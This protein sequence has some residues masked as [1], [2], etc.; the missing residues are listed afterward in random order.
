MGK[1]KFLFD[2]P[3][4]SE[5]ERKDALAKWWDNQGA[6][7]YYNDYSQGELFDEEDYESVS[8]K[9]GAASDWWRGYFGKNSRSRFYG[10]YGGYIDDGGEEHE[11]PE[12]LRLKDEL[13]Q[14]AR[15]VNAVR[16]TS[17]A[18]KRERNLKVAWAGQGFSRADH[19]QNNMRSTSTIYISPD[20][21]TE[22][23]TIKAK[24][25]EGQKRDA[26]VGEALS[27]TA[28]KRI[29]QPSHVKQIMAN[30]QP[31]EYIAQLSL[32]EIDE[33]ERAVQLMI[34][35]ELWKSLE[36]YTAQQDL[37]KDYRGC[38]A[39]FAAYLAFY[40]D[41]GYKS[42]L[43]A[44]MQDEPEKIN[45]FRAAAVL[46]W[47]IN[48]FGH[49]S[50][51][52]NPP[53]GDVEEIMI[54][55]FEV[56]MEGLNL[57]STSQRW[58]KAVEAAQI[59]RDLDPEGKDQDQ[60][61]LDQSG[62]DA[63]DFMD[64]ANGANGNTENMF[65]AQVQNASQMQ[66]Q[67]DCDDLED[68]EQASSGLTEIS[69]T[70][71]LHEVTDASLAHG[72]M[73][74]RWNRSVLEADRIADLMRQI[75]EETAMVLAS[76][77]KV[78]EPYAHLPVLPEY[79]M[80]SG[81]LS[82]SSL[83]KVTTNL[84]DNDRVFFRK[85]TQGVTNKV[86]IGLLLDYSGST[87]GGVLDC[88]KRIAVILNDLFSMFHQVDLHLFGHE[89]GNYNNIYHFESLKGTLAYDSGGGTNEGTALACA[90]KALNQVTPRGRRKI[91]FAIGDG[92]TGPDEIKASVK[93][94][95]QSG[96]EVYDILVTQ[97]DDAKHQAVDC[98]GEGRVVTLDPWTEIQESN[99]S[100]SYGDNSVLIDV[101]MGQ[102]TRIMRPWLVQMFA[103]LNN[104]GSL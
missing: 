36:T 73:G 76:L 82:R 29:V 79:G 52:V 23:G 7:D 91:L 87:H 101:L 56:L 46:A 21:L 47:N 49:K 94:I 88:E 9:K 34:A 43:I 92:C 12:Q 70:A 80:R 59:L 27:L 57:R 3:L 90:A 99:M 69:E 1:A 13:R 67:I 77:K 83:W 86:S 11:P 55:A 95:R 102:L 37:L 48:H 17:G 31:G 89:D 32:L 65:G 66:G 68:D 103:R 98:Y 10:G 38:R 18:L 50:D 4:A 19:N 45:A 75:R 72:K 15:T 97:Y 63:M 24:W 74:G 84:V 61:F 8:T 71:K 85:V 16:N 14:I 54:E 44:S 30:K 40:S 93:A 5:V 100:T 22:K 2:K 42:K 60:E 39:Y 78:V 6:E 96:M 28:M 62:Q 51:Q 58:E 64:G 25:T 41:E 104:M 33:R 53:P 35:R 20:P 26:L 81:R